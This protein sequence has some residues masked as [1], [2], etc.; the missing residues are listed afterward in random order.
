MRET[1][2]LALEE[3]A[4]KLS[5]AERAEFWPELW[6]RYVEN[7]LDYKSPEAVLKQK[8]TQAGEDS[9]RLLEWLEPLA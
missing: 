1:L 3:L 4:A 8:Q 9:C 2:R 5:E 6:E 7:K